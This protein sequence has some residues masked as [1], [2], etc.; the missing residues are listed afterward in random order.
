LL[1]PSIGEGST[2]DGTLRFDVASMTAPALTNA[3]VRL[4]VVSKAVT[5]TPL[6]G[7]ATTAD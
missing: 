4:L 6:L 3:R 1:A 2:A 7:G 5:L